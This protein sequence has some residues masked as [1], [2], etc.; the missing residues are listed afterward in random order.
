VTAN[1]QR[2]PAP[3]GTPLVIGSCPA[4]TGKL[5]GMVDDIGLFKRGLTKDE[6]IDIRDQGLTK[7]LAISPWG[8]L[9]SVW[10]AVKSV[11]Y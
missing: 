9:A 10:G 8:N 7:A 1:K 11:T 3:T 2:I 4:G 5:A 6:I